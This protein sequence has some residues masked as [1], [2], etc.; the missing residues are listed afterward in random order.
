MP[1]L[2]AD[3]VNLFPRF[4]IKFI[5]RSEKYISLVTKDQYI[6]SMPQFCGGYH[7]LSFR[8]LQAV[9]LF[10]DLLSETRKG[11]VFGDKIEKDTFRF[12]SEARSLSNKACFISKEEMDGLLPPSISPLSRQSNQGTMRRRA[13]SL[14]AHLRCRS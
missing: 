10:Y 9:L 8:I 4:G 2:F 5:S 13:A 11:R 14:A 1:L 3:T 12:T 7:R 6:R